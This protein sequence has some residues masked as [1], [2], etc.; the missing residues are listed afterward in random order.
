MGDRKGFCVEPLSASIHLSD[1]TDGTMEYPLLVGN[2]NLGLGQRPY[3]SSQDFPYVLVTDW[4]FA[5]NN[6]RRYEP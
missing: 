2:A 5:F 1:H 6:S 4:I 3:G